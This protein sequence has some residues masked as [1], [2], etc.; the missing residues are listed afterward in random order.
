MTRLRS[1]WIV[2][3][4]EFTTTVLRASFLLVLVGLPAAHLA[5][6]ALLGLSLQLA[7]SEKP[8]PPVAVVDQHHLLRDVSEGGVV[9]RDKDAALRDLAAQRLDAVFVLRG[10]YLTTGHVDVYDRPAATLAEIGKGLENHE[11]ASTVIRR[12]L[13]APTDDA[14]SERL[15]QPLTDTTAWRVEGSKVERRVAPP[16]VD[17][18]AGPFGVCFIMGLSIFLASGLLQQAMAAELQ[19][20][21]LEVMLS[22]ITPLQLLTGKVLGLAAAGLLQ[23]VVYL[24]ITVG[25]APLV[26][27]VSIP[28]SLVAWSAAIFLAGYLLFAVLMAGTGALARDAQ[29]VPQLASLWMLLAAAPFFVITHISSAPTSWLAQL[30]TWLPPT[31]PVALLLRMSSGATSALERAAVV[32]A[33]VL[34]AWV[35]LGLSAR[36]FSA[37]VQASGQLSLRGVFWK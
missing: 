19:N 14:R 37:R 12:G 36:L 18:F 2:A 32:G 4:W 16:L 1:I 28:W 17:V 7:A 30:L 29:E 6:A 31:A 33:I 34:C 8:R 35:A 10:D 23:V 3:R 13:T 22:V 5:L 21:M 24:A 15:I 27:G 20:R 26:G 25:I 11:R 9:L